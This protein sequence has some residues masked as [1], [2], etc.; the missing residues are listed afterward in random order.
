[1]LCSALLSWVKVYAL[2]ISLC[3]CLY[4]SILV[5]SLISHVWLKE[6][7]IR[8]KEKTDQVTV[9]KVAM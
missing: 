3:S 2:A 1:M 9:A 6:M 7:E 8:L 5:L 4:K